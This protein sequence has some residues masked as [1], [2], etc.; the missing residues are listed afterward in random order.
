M[1]QRKKI[2]HSLL[3]EIY[4]DI[5]SICGSLMLVKNDNQETSPQNK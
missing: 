1:A 2:T 5:T 4:I 3:Q